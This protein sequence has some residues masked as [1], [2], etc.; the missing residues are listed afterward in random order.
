MPRRTPK[1]P[2]KI[3]VPPKKSK[4]K[5]RAAPRAEGVLTAVADRAKPVRRKLPRVRTP[6]TDATR[7]ERM[8]LFLATYR[9]KGIVRV[10]L[11]KV[12]IT[13]ATLKSWIAEYAEFARL[14]A[15]ADEDAIDLL[16]LEAR[17]RAHDGVDKPIT[18]KG[19]VTSTFKEYSDRVLVEMLSARRPD[20][21]GKHRTEISG[22]GG[23]PLE[24]KKVE[25]V[26]VQPPEESK[27]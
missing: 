18:Y 19:R 12:G 7:E 5:R 2:P 26:V 13:R 14:Y 9:E 20:K 17:R 16:E 22:P 6:M 24:I 21:Y 3:S 8:A 25:W 23:G 1:R 4:P 10:A 27:K 15:D 11:E